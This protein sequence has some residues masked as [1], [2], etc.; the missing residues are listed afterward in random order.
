M[1]Q[2]A[3]KL[4]SRLLT[5]L[6]LLL[7]WVAVS[8]GGARSQSNGKPN[9]LPPSA[10]DARPID[11][12]VSVREVSP[13]PSGND[14]QRD[15]SPLQTRDDS[16]RPVPR[17]SSTTVQNDRPHIP[18]AAELPPYKIVDP[19]RHARRTVLPDRKC[20]RSRDIFG[21]IQ[22]MSRRGFIRVI[23]VP[24]EVTELKGFVDSPSGWIAYGF[25]VPPRGK[26]HVRL[27][28]PNES[29]FRL[30]MMNRWGG[31]EAGMLQNLIP[32]GNPEVTYTN[33]TD[34]F[35]A[36]YVLVDDPGLM[37]REGNPFTLKIDRSWDPKEN[38]PAAT[39][40]QG[41]WASGPN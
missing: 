18:I 16:Y 14:S 9:E 10:T 33:P 1:T 11:P 38:R 2:P 41:I 37:S 20:W 8:P 23:P 15:S 32:T 3:G 17:R 36:V 4:I 34:G 25:P 13:P 22:W 19:P 29:W 6:G 26:L 24:D 40:L 12:P 27:Y 21:E 28:H 35:K 31:L 7:I 39:V 5:P 30:L